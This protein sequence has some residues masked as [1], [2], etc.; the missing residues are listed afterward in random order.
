MTGN[1]LTALTEPTLHPAYAASCIIKG[2][3]SALE[4]GELAPS[5]G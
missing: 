1:N 2:N 4:T 5:P 3:D